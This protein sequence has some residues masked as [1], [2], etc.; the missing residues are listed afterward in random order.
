MNFRAS[1]IIRLSITLWFD[2]S[3]R[4]RHREPVLEI[5]LLSGLA[6]LFQQARLAPD[7]KRICTF[8]RARM[9]GLRAAGAARITIT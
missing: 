9:P 1:F 5:S 8:T 2:R 7:S 4:M 3:D 6:K